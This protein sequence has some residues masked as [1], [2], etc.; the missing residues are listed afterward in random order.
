[1]DIQADNVEITIQNVLDLCRG[2][3]KVSKALEGKIRE[4]YIQCDSLKICNLLSMYEGG[5]LIYIREGVE[6]HERQETPGR[7]CH[8]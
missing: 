4:R 7:G 1:M 2:C 8:L 5:M 3:F 6:H